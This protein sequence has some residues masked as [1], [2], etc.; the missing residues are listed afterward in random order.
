MGAAYF[1][2]N[3]KP[4]QA[5]DL[6]QVVKASGGRP[7][8]PDVACAQHEGR[9]GKPHRTQPAVFAADKITQL[10]SDQ[11]C[12]GAGMLLDHQVVPE[13]MKRIFVAAEQIKVQASDLIHSRGDLTYGG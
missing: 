12:I 6:M 1:L 4:G 10:R 5:H 11:G 13:A 2:S 8:D 9:R 7:T 3:Q